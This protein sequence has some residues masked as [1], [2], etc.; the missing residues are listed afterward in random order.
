MSLR[1]QKIL[2]RIKWLAILALSFLTLFSYTFRATA[3]NHRG[4]NGPG[5][6]SPPPSG[7]YGGRVWGTVIVG[8]QPIAGAMVSMIYNGKTITTTTL[9]VPDF[10]S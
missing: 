2:H 5:H 4:L 3:T 7:D 10:E 6:F 1:F 9:W 8:E